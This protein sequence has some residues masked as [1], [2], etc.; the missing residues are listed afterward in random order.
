MI[1]GVGSG[2]ADGARLLDAFRQAFFGYPDLGSRPRVRVDQWNG[3]S[4]AE[5]RAYWN[6]GIT[7][8]RRFSGC[9]AAAGQLRALGQLRYEPAVGMLIGLR[10]ECPVE[11]IRIAADHM[12]FSIGT[13][14]ARA[15]LRAA[16]DDCE[17]FDRFMAVKTMF[18]D[19]GTAWDNVGWLFSGD[20]LSTARRP[21]GCRSSAAFPVAVLVFPDG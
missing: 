11:P 10:E 14:E 5:K 7:A 3:L 1:D 2:E 9:R 15:A 19:G 4:P 20:R 8:I 6:V 18:P 16:L 12:L 17:H 21:R 13:S